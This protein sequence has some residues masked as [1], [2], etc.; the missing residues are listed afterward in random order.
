M[1]S[2]HRILVAMGTR[3]EVIKLAPLVGALRARPD[4]FQTVVCATAQHR[5]MLDQALEVFDLEPDVDLD[6][7]APGQDIFDVTA[8]VLLAMRPVLAEHQPDV[9]IVQGDTTTAFTVALAAFYA[10]RKVAHVE[11]G[12][13]S[14]DKFQP[15]PEEINRVL[16]SSLTDFHFPPTQGSRANLLKAGYPEKD[17]LVTGNTVIDALYQSLPRARALGGIA[18]LTL[19]PSRRLVLVTGHRRENFGPGVAS[20]CEALADLVRRREDLEIVYPVHLNPNVRGPVHERLGALA[21]M[22]LIEPL[23]YLPFL[24]LMDR[25]YLLLTDSGGVQEEGPALGKPVLVMR[26]VTERPEAVEVGAAALVGTDR[27]RIVESV[28]RLLDDPAH[29]R[30]MATAGSPYGDGKACQRIV[31][32][33]EKRLAQPS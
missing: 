8:R 9:V 11:A 16:A 14:F 4:R 5:Q 15:F 22:H 7:M 13:R 19:D 1:S 27:E 12:L 2:P 29:Y 6:L 17:V 20:M 32:F 30:S 21:R 3:P 31:E 26:E 33:L 18:G 10:R 25:A 28:E 23:S 24:W